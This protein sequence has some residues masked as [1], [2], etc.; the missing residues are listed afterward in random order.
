M[1]KFYN[2]DLML[3][4]KVFV[5]KGKILIGYCVVG[6]LFDFVGIIEGKR[7]VVYF[8]VKLVVSKGMVIDERLVVDGNFYIV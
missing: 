6:L 1:D 2:V 3:V 4:L 5:G 7:L 8:L